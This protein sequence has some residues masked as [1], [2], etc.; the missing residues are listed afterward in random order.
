MNALIQPSRVTTPRAKRC[1]AGSCSI[2]REAR[3]SRAAR[4]H[5]VFVEI[6]LAREPSDDAKRRL[7]R[8]LGDRLG[9]ASVRPDDGFVML[10]EYT[11]ADWSQAHGEAPLLDPAASP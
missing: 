6:T 4:E 7:Y 10:R 3:A 5:V 11:L 8:E 9:D 2:H 1:V